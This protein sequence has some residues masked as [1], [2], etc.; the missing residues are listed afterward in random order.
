MSKEITDVDKKETGF[1][2]SARTILLSLTGLF[3][4]V[5]AL[6][7]SGIDVYKS[8]I[9]IPTN[10]YDKTNNELFVKHFKEKPI[11][12]QTVEIKASNLTVPMLLEVYNAGDIYVKYGD[13]D[14]WLPFTK[15]KTTAY[16]IFSEAYADTQE[17]SSLQGMI[18]AENLP[19]IVID[20]DKIERQRQEHK[21]REIPSNVLPPT[22]QR[23]FLIAEI[24]D[25][26]NFFS[27][28]SGIYEKTFSADDGYKITS[29]S[30]QPIS[31]NHSKFE[32]IELLND[33]QSV[34]IVF[35]MSSGAAFDRW[36]GWFKGT[37][38]TKQEKTQ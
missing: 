19:P 32:G 20:I 33:G 35:S 36:R 14:Q 22:I 3:I 2:G 6:V 5:P 16:S 8:V 4:A 26:H 23:E 30:F 28:S 11:V 29:S 13:F 27:S 15:L 18:I 17:A 31:L 7:N 38:I 1:F 24:R 21:K 12:S 9:N 10:I 37:L 34:K 25:I